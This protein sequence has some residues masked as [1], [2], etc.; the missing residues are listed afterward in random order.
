MERPLNYFEDPNESKSLGILLVDF[1]QYYANGF[2]YTTHAISASE[3]KL[4]TKESK[5][6]E[7][8]SN[9][10]ALSIQCLIHPEKDVAKGCGKIRAVRAA[11]DRG[12]LA[13]EGADVSSSI[14]KKFIGIPQSLTEDRS[15]VIHFVD[16]GV[17]QKELSL[18]STNEQSRRPSR[19]YNGYASR[20]YEPYRRPAYRGQ[21]YRGDRN[22]QSYRPDRYND[23][24]YRDGARDGSS[25]R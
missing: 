22:G 13:L 9:P 24:Y 5:E 11:F 18:L 6:W 8:K 17:L 4:I 7:S 21:T 14:L 15:A 20:S 2:P 1:L 12:R 25:R 10:E 3:K 19:Y 23:R 16:S